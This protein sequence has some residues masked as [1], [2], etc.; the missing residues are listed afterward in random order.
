MKPQLLA[1]AL[2]ASCLI[3]APVASQGN[4]GLQPEIVSLDL[5]P[6][7]YASSRVAMPV[8][9]FKPTLTQSDAGSGPWPVVIFSHGRAGSPVG[10]AA[11]KSAVH[12]YFDMVRYWHTKGYAVVAAVRP[13]YGENAAE[14]PEDHGARWTG[15]TCRGAVDFSK[16]AAAATHAMRRVHAWAVEQRWVNKE[17]V[18]LVGQSV[19]GLTTVAACGQNWPGVIGCINF[20]GGAGGNPDASPGASCRADRLGEHLASAAKTTAVPSLWLYSANDLFWGEQA[21]KEWHKAYLQAAA[22]AGSQVPSEFFAAPAVGE[23]GHSLMGAGSRF[24][25]PVVDVWLHK[26]GF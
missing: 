13:G 24:W 12:G 17:R 3:P 20:A 1:L 2:A 5:P 9:V 4:S 25:V 18:L 19:G 26:N 16:T 22:A 14:D 21:P 6:S 10:R 7:A 15:S 23:N 11:M 8:Q